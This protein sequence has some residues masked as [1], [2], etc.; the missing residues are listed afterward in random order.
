MSADFTHLVTL[1][2]LGMGYRGTSVVHDVNLTVEKG[3]IHALVGVNGAGKTTLMRGI[4]GMLRPS[5]GSISVLGRR[6]NTAH[7][8]MWARVGY[9]LD[10]AFT[11]REL[12]GRENI[13]A[14]ARMHGISKTEASAATEAIIAAFGLD[15]EAG[16]RV[17]T[18][19]LGNRQRVA[20]AAAMAHEPELL[21]LDEPTT[22]LDPLAV[23]SL[24][25]ALNSATSRGAGILVSSHHLDE[26]ARIADTVTVLH[27]GKVIADL[28]PGG[29]DLEKRFFD[30]V[31]AAELGASS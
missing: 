1:D 13:Y 19:S 16:K 5:A 21:I 2:G 15:R 30:L 18:L 23:V 17:R 22:S 14:S 24:R 8:S 10:T 3:R 29:V 9:I 31:Y 27:R 26:V 28:D 7:P 11:Y 20:L 6:P 25:R 12:T 4:L